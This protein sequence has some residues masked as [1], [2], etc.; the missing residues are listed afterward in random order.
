MQ[1]PSG[2][3]Q[4]RSGWPTGHVGWSFNGRAQFEGRVGTFLAEG[5]ARR[6]QLM[7]VSDD[8]TPALWPK[9]LIDEGALLVRSTSEVYGSGRTV[10]PARQRQ[11]FE[12]AL[13]EATSLGF[14][15]LR[16]AADNTSLVSTPERLTAWSAWE[17]EAES[18]T[19]ALPIYALCSFDRTR[20]GPRIL[21]AVGRLHQVQALDRPAQPS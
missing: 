2:D 12:Q 7:L 15:G 13:A 5:A 4:S 10:D 3:K 20:L 21:A 8:P 17:E 1:P 9:A 18:M 16:V 6:E 14:A 19:Q 11:L